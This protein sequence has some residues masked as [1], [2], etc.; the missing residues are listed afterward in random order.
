MITAILI[1]VLIILIV[2]VWRIFKPYLIKH[3]T[4][5]LFTGGLGAGKTL[6]AVKKSIILIRKQRFYKY[7][8]YNFFRCKIGNFFRRLFNY[9]RLKKGNRSHL[10]GLGKNSYKFYNDYCNIHKDIWRK[11]PFL[12]KLKHPKPMLYSNI[13]IHFKSHIFKRKREWAEKLTAEHVLLLKKITEYSVSLID[14]FP[15]FVNQFNW[16][17][18][19][20]QTNINEWITF[21]R[22][23]I[24]GYLLAT[25]QSE[26]DIV[27]QV[28]RK[29]NQAIW[30][31][32][33]KK[34]FFGLFY[35]NKMCD[36]MLSDNISTMTTTFIEENTRTHFGLF[37]PRKTYDTRCYSIRYEN[38]LQKANPREFFDNVKT[39]SVLRIT[40]YIS[41]LDSKTTYAEKMSQLYTAIRLRNEKKETQN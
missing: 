36:I 40:D 25:S 28:R 18:E 23:Y 13:P 5:I 17:E 6:E 15:Q 34:H 32:D 27:V 21:Y 11:K 26:S 10:K 4:T 39:Y 35:T 24:G 22:H 38:I 41:P 20:V 1:L 31:F 30:C 33:F 19:L 7:Y 16:N 9:C 37:P 29:L 3:D 12:M 14:E 8:C 2:I